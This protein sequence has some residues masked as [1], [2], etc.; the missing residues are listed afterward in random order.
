MDNHP[1]DRLFREK[2][3]PSQEQWPVNEAA[4]DGAIAHIRAQELAERRKRRGA[5]L[6]WIAVPLLVIFTLVGIYR[7]NTAGE[8]VPMENVEVEEAQMMQA[9]GVDRDSHNEVQPEARGEVAVGEEGE[10]QSVA[11][12][13]DQNQREVVP[14][15]RTSA[16]KRAQVGG[17]HK[18]NQDGMH[19]GKSAPSVVEEG[20]AYTGEGMGV[21][22]DHLRHSEPLAPLTNLGWGA[23]VQ[24]MSGSGM[25]LGIDEVWTHK[26]AEV[27]D[28]DVAVPARLKTAWV[29]A[30]SG[31]VQPGVLS[32]EAPFQDY[33][34]RIGRRWAL[35]D[36]LAVE[37]M[38]GP[39]FFSGQLPI[40]AQSAHVSYDVGTEVTS[41]HLQADKLAFLGTEVGLVYG[42]QR[43]RMSTHIGLDVLVGA[44]GTFSTKHFSQEKK[45]QDR[46]YRAVLI[47]EQRAW[48]DING[49]NQLQWS[50]AIG[51]HYAITRSFEVGVLFTSRFNELV[52][53]DSYDRHRLGISIKKMF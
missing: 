7:A 52:E 1:I 51:Y 38:A 10:L 3:Q 45:L 4:L 25:E 36:Y 39:R 16:S 6:W 21:R 46:E 33:D 53:T 20:S 47:N 14:S 48:L 19:P 43:H 13:V 44:Y 2:L 29:V 42:H 34:L 40:H 31:D 26:Y 30:A 37:A 27:V 17:A 9:N 32:I 15:E 28:I 11:S 49:L 23:M 35:L 24:S 22:P 8:V 12:P 5:F 18:D 41:Y 50:S